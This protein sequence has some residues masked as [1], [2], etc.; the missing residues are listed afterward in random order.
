ML[1]P[2]SRHASAAV[3]SAASLGYFLAI[4]AL[5]QTLDDDEYGV[6]AVL[7]TFLSFLSTFGA[8][9][10]EQV[11]V[12]TAK[13]R[14]DQS[15][16][17]DP[18]LVASLAVAATIAPISGAVAFRWL[19]QPL[20]GLFVVSLMTA[21]AMVLHNLLKL[22]RDFSF[23]QLAGNSWKVALACTTVMVHFSDSVSLR[24]LLTLYQAT[25]VV[26]VCICAGRLWHLR[27]MFRTSDVVEAW[28]YRLIW[29]FLVSM[30]LLAA[31]N[32]FDRLLGAVSLSLQEIGQYFLW[33]TLVVF[34]NTVIATYVAFRLVVHYRALDTVPAIEMLVLKLLAIGTTLAFASLA[35]SLGAAHLGLIDAGP[36]SLGLASALVLLGGVRLAYSVCSAALGA[37]GTAALIGSANRAM[38]VG[39]LVFS[40]AALFLIRSVGQLAIAFLLLWLYRTLVFLACLRRIAP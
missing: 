31:T 38:L 24:D 14:D 3:L 5:K 4:V 30:A 23:S 2:I 9:G 25:L 34:P 22:G 21:L 36:I 29:S 1:F 15:V 18:T 35:S 17:L 8:L 37:F 19:Y 40:I 6:L 11:L 28:D 20:D 27:H 32:N 10:L 7:L 12:R 39:L 26:F 16:S 13:I 33:S